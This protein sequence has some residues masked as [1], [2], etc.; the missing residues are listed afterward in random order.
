MTSTYTISPLKSP[1]IEG[2]WLD[3]LLQT[4]GVAQGTRLYYSLRGTGI[5]RSDFQ[6]SLNGNGLI[7]ANGRLSFRRLVV[8]D[9]LAEGEEKLRID[10]RADVNGKRQ[11]VARHI[12]PLLDK[13]NTPPP[14]P[15]TFSLTP[16]SSWIFEGA[17]ITSSIKTTN[18]NP[19]S[20]LYYKFY[21]DGIDALD[22]STNLTGSLQLD[23][24]G[25]AQIITTFLDDGIKEGIS[26]FED[27][28]LSLY[29]RPEMK[30]AIATTQAR[31]YDRINFNIMP[32]G[33]SITQGIGDDSQGGYRTPLYNSLANRGYLFNFV[34]NRVT[35]GDQ[36]PDPD[37]WGRPG[38]LIDAAT[39][40]IY[41]NLTGITTTYNYVAQRQR[42]STN[43]PFS[44]PLAKQLRSAI[45]TQYFSNDPNS[46]NVMLVMA[47]TND[48]A[49]QVADKSTKDPIT[50]ASPIERGDLLKDADHEFQ[51]STGQATFNRMQSFL[52]QANHWA[53]KANLHIHLVLGTIPQMLK[54]STIHPV[55]DTLIN[56]I[57]IYNQAIVNTYGQGVPDPF[58]HLS[59][60]VASTNQGIGANLD[61][62]IH[63]NR[64][65]YLGMADAWLTA[66]H[67]GNFA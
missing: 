23:N 15:P 21:G 64:N 57:S 32:F 63:P 47:G 24:N 55:S 51:W 52:Q 12:V 60:T 5:T 56:Q 61:D 40:S 39:N 13:S 53:S 3:V 43:D 8:D 65:G 58:S 45:S 59:V 37:H 34:G 16:S 28:S 4:T 38:W 22:I 48:I 27:V 20:T 30:A 7:D 42:P 6:G 50:G 44:R 49:F 17:T 46:K 1:V 62:G 67:P 36:T 35:P 25:E 18:L 2:E 10:L 66:L 41:D 33:D 54:T 9:G 19:G 31:V 11:L 29:D 14:P 26:G